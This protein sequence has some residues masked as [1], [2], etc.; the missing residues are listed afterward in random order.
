MCSLADTSGV[1]VSGILKTKLTEKFA[2]AE[3]Q[4]INESYMHNVPKGGLFFHSI[5]AVI[6]WLID[7]LIDKLLGV[8]LFSQCSE[9]S[10]DWLAD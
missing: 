7:W 2:P 1:D 9:R 3:L 8:N 4:V 10:I 6:R 5:G